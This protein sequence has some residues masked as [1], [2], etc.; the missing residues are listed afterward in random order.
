MVLVQST[1]L[2]RCDPDDGEGTMKLIE[3][4][5]TNAGR[6]QQQ[7]LMEILTRNAGT[8]YLRGFLDG[9]IDRDLFKKEVPIVDYEQV[10]PYIERLANGEPSTIISSQP[11]TELLTRFVLSHPVF[12]C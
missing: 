4:L 8:E 5:T 12:C 11:I 9:K 7:M 1:M 10:K 3:D 6:T 2:F